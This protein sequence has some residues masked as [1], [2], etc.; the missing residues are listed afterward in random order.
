MFV[1][2]S[3][4]ACR[5]LINHMQT[6]GASFECSIAVMFEDTCGFGQTDFSERL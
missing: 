1:V 2:L 4:L 5:V 3:G 6:K